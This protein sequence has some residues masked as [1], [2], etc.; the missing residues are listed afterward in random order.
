MRDRLGL[1]F[2][3]HQEKAVEVNSRQYL[4]L[5][6]VK[7]LDI[8]IIDDAEDNENTND[9]NTNINDDSTV[10]DEDDTEIENNDTD[11]VTDI[12][13]LQK[14]IDGSTVDEVIAMVEG[15]QISADE[16]IAYE[17]VGKNRPTLLDKLEELK[18]GD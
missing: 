17:T 16:A 13:E 2:V 10:M 15:G 5:K 9:I 11:E 7:D 8:T 1:R 6:A 4:T 18:Q 14:E 3:P 12:Q